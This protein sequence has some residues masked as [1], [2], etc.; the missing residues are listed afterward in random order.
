ME[1]ERF[2]IRVVVGD[3]EGRPSGDSFCVSGL[4]ED[5]GDPEVREVRG[6]IIS[7]D[8]PSQRRVFVQEQGSGM[9]ER[10][11][12]KV[13]DWVRDNIKVTVEKL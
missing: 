3:P 1:T 7:R 6:V 8:Y 13:A 10:H 2:Y 11:A 5:E 12:E 9:A 4:Y